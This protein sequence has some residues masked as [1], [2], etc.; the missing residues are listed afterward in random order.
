M[1][2]QAIAGTFTHFLHK[3]DL[4]RSSFD[5]CLDFSVKTPAK[6][7]SLQVFLYTTSPK[8]SRSKC[9]SSFSSKV[10]QE[11]CPLIQKIFV[12]LNGITLLPGKLGCW[13]N[14]REFFW[15]ICILLFIGSSSESVSSLAQ[16]H[17]SDQLFHEIFSVGSAMFQRVVR[18]AKAF[19]SVL[20]R[21]QGKH[22]RPLRLALRYFIFE[23]RQML[24]RI[25][26][27]LNVRIGQPLMLNYLLARKLTRYFHI[28]GT[29]IEVR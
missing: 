19:H 12:H 18:Q 9:H 11:C 25:Y 8:S 22:W 7:I 17:K 23:P 2:S 24:Q 4:V 3:N 27:F 26:L 21:M 20:R 1:S 6:Q 10:G 13:S 14:W 15:S 28:A 16:L 5:K 29:M